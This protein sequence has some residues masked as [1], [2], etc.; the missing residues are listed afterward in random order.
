MKRPKMEL[1][2]VAQIEDQLALSMLQ[3]IVELITVA[4]LVILTTA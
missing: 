2:K 1:L 3:R 4:S